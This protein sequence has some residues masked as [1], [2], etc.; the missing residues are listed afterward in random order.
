M[1]RT[2]ST[3]VAAA[4]WVAASAWLFS[5]S[6]GPG[7]VDRLLL[8]GAIT[9]T[10]VAAIDRGAAQLR[11]VARIS[12]AAGAASRVPN[13]RTSAEDHSADGRDRRA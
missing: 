6:G 10:V 3:V 7:D 2:R 12:W 8:A 9:S 11:E 4:L 1:V 5:S 13:S